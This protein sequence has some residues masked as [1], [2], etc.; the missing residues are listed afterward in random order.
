MPAS[1]EM[2]ATWPSPPFALA[3]QPKQEFALRLPP[4]E[5]R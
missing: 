5:R 2:S 1:P 3:Q 4:D